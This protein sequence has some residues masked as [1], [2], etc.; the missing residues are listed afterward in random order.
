MTNRLINRSERLAEIERLLV[1]STSGL[2]VVEVA[3]AC[4]VDR[5]TIYRD[6]TLLGEVG[7]PIYQKEGRF[8]LSHEHYVASARLSLNESVALFIAAR[9]MSHVTE[10]HNPHLSSALNKLSMILPEPLAAHL[11]HLIESVRIN[12]VDRAFVTVLET[13]T[14]AWAERSKVKLWYRSSDSYNTRSH[15]F[16]TYFIEPTANGSLYAIGYD[17]VAQRVRAFKLERIKRI[18][19]LPSRYDIPSFFDRRRYLAGLWGMMRGETSDRP[20]EVKLAFSPDL[21]PLIKERVRVA[22][23]VGMG[24]TAQIVTTHDNRWILNLQISDWRDALPWVRSLGTHVEVLEP[25]V[26]RDE[27]AAEAQKI[28]GM[29]AAQAG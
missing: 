26:L 9:G 4:G 27:I 20:I 10:Q 25:K 24:E 14:R 18:Q 21:A 1:R 13:F 11:L 7:L 19:I 12:P 17:Y 16:A 6:L 22:V 23:G 2:R 8:Y 28:V 15:E 3:E 29:Y 5:R